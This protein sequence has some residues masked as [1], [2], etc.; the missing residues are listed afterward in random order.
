M[1]KMMMMNE[2]GKKGRSEL[3]RLSVGPR[4]SNA[5]P[6][7]GSAAVLLC[8]RSLLLLYLDMHTLHCT[9]ALCGSVCLW[10]MF[11]CSKMLFCSSNAM[12]LF[13]CFILLLYAHL[14]CDV[15]IYMYSSLRC[16]SSPPK[17]L[18]C[19]SFLTA[20]MLFLCF[21]W[22]ISTSMLLSSMFIDCFDAILCYTMLCH[23]WSPLLWN[24]MHNSL[25]FRLVMFSRCSRQQ[26]PRKSKGDDVFETFSTNPWPLFAS[27]SSSLLS[28]K[29][30]SL[31]NVLK[32]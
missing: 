28:T 4:R 8:C 2:D 22:L 10:Y 17:W 6:A 16:Y 13:C 3:Y 12:L 1:M 25:L 29:K 9:A 15:C 23:W 5:A 26:V 24:L 31:V 32:I 30:W 19:C 14:W 21:S 7:D 18:C 11:I 20:L 27:S